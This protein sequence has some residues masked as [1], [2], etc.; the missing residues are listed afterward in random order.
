[1]ASTFAGPAWLPK[2]GPL[3]LVLSYAIED[4][5]EVDR[6][7]S[8]LASARRRGVFDQWDQSL[9]GPVDRRAAI[10]EK[11]ARAHVIAPLLSPA[12]L[13]SPCFD[14]ELEIARRRHA[15]WSSRCCSSP[16]T[17]T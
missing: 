6:L 2:T 10:A 14:E 16:A 17:W 15:C 7:R 5:A 13:A 9:A 1:M 12:Y 11:L 4:G 8:H 3:K